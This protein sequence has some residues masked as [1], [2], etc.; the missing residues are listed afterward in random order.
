MLRTLLITTAL[1]AT[2]GTAFAHDDYGYGRVVSVEPQISISF[3]TRHHDGF[4]VLYESGGYRYWT[5]TSYHPGH[6]IVLPQHH[7][8]SVRHVY[9]YRD[10]HGWNDGP[11]WDDGRGWRKEHRGGHHKHRRHDRD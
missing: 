2:A 9:Q 8:H 10:D 6:V 5:H 3:G 7:H 11:R 1:M 4:R